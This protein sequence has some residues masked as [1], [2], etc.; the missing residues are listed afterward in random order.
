[1]DKMADKLNIKSQED[2]YLVTKEILRNNGGN[3]LLNKYG[4]I[5]KLLTTVYPEYR[6][7]N[8]ELDL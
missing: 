3:P 1:M 2:W 6:G 5:A 8:N 4:S 7:Q